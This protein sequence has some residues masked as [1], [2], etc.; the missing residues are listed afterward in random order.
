VLVHSSAVVTVEQH[1]HYLSALLSLVATAHRYRSPVAQKEPAFDPTEPLLQTPVPAQSSPASS[2]A[3]SSPHLRVRQAVAQCIALGATVADQS[4]VLFASDEARLFPSDVPASLA[5]HRA[6]LHAHRQ[7]HRQHPENIHAGQRALSAVTAP[8]YSLSSANPS[9]SASATSASA[10]AL[11]AEALLPA[12]ASRA[13][14]SY[15]TD[16]TVLPSSAAGVKGSAAGSMAAPFL[17]ERNFLQQI[18]QAAADWYGMDSS[19]VCRFVC[20]CVWTCDRLDG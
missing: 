12:P 19:R 20:V 7:S 6:R 16:V 15:L 9:A 13:L 18:T 8:L 10:L 4:A 17:T 11:P 14:Q 2:T 1:I 5:Q 3:T